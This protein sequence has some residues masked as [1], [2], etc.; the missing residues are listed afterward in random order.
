MYPLCQILNKTNKF[1][2]LS[3]HCRMKA[4]AQPCVGNKQLG[5]S[6]LLKGTK[7]VKAVA[8]ARIEPTIIRDDII[9]SSYI[10]SF[11]EYVNCEE[12]RA[13]LGNT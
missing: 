3:I 6:T 11:V 7:Y 8:S 13:L 4:S 2:A 5:I 10:Q 1:Q 12:P 9:R